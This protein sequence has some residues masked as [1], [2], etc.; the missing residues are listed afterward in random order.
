MDVSKLT[1]SY[2]ME[3]VAGI[4]RIILEP[5]YA[6]AI[7]SVDELVYLLEVLQEQRAIYERDRDEVYLEAD[8]SGP[9]AVH[10]TAIDLLLSF[11]DNARVTAVFD[12]LTSRDCWKVTR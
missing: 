5:G 6:H 7:Q 10:Q 11:V 2:W 4:R 12:R 1:D 3:E 8:N 9:A